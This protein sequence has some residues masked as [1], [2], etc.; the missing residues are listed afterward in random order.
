MSVNPRSRKSHSAPSQIT[1]FE[2]FKSRYLK[3]LYITTKIDKHADLQCDFSVRGQVGS[4]S[5]PVRN[6]L[7]G[8]AT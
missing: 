5:N 7:N 1:G 4:I 6:T 2:I 8:V 3:N